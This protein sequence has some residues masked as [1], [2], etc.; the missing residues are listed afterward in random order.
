MPEDSYGDRFKNGTRGRILVVD[1]SEL[2]LDITRQALTEADYDVRTNTS[3]V[4][5]AASVREFQPDLILLDLNMPSIAGDNICEILKRSTF[6]KDIPII[7]FTSQ[8]EGEVKRIVE[9]VGAD[10]YIIKEMDKKVIVDEVNFFFRKHC[11]KPF[12]LSDREE[13]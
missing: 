6:G 7:L 5:V 4:E 10:G 2:I 13:G 11:G 3:W 1:D 8:D 9:K 12:H